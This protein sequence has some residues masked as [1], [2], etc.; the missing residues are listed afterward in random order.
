MKLRIVMKNPD[1]LGTSLTKALLIEA[2]EK[3]IPE[4]EKA[5]WV[6]SEREELAEKMKKWFKHGEYIH[7]EIDTDTMVATVATVK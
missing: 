6:E 7:L 5:D 3:G 2:E 1:V 4:D